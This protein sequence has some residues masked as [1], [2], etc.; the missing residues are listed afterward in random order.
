M[1][2]VNLLP[3]E[4]RSRQAI[5]QRTILVAVIGA[6]VVLL[7]LA[8]YFLQ[9]YNLSKANDELAA[10]QQQNDQLQAQVASLSQ[11]GDL[12]QQ[13]KTKQDLA[14]AVFQDEVAWSGIL[15]DLSRT[16]PPDA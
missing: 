9:V 16:M 8:F 11:Y 12:Q 5:R 1:S 2:R 3:P 7:I 15:M 4:I 6:G 13:L 10:Q 14:K